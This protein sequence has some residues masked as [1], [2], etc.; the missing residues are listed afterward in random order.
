SDVSTSIELGADEHPERRRDHPLT[1]AHARGAR[2]VATACMLD[3]PRSVIA[4]DVERA[5]VGNP[6]PPRLATPRVQAIDPRQRTHPVGDAGIGRELDQIDT[7][8]CDDPLVAAR[9]GQGAARSAFRAPGSLLPRISRGW[10][11]RPPSRP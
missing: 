4:C 6:L 10:L 9:P 7:G 8:S 5:A 11:L 2:T 1:R 3:T